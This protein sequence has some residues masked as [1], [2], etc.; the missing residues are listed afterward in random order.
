MKP[1]IFPPVFGLVFAIMMWALDKHLPLAN[2]INPPIN[3]TGFIFI[4]T[5]LLVDLWSLY[6]FV[7]SKTTFHPL[8]LEETSTI[9]TTGMYR[10]SRNPM[11]LGML[12]LLIGLAI[13]LGSL[14]PFLILPLFVLVINHQQIRHEE[15]MLLDKFGQEYQEYKMKVRR[16]I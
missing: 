2:I 16:W 6:L 10:I 9:V 3:K 11:Y 8:K 12:L 5:G 4:G 7:K 13:L 14:S 1:R 15:A